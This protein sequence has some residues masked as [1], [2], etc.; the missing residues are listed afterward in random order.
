MDVV[1]VGEGPAIEEVEA[2]LGDVN[3]SP[4]RTTPE[5]IEEAGFAIVVDDVGS[6]TFQK[7]NEASQAGE[8][9]WI[10][11]EDGGVGGLRRSEVE[12]GVSGYSPAETGCYECLATRVEAG[13][14]DEDV[15]AP[16]DTTSSL[17]FGGAIAGR[18]T[19]HLLTG[20]VST[21]LGGVTEIPLDVER[22]G[23]LPTPGC[24]CQDPPDI[25]K[26]DYQPPRSVEDMF[27]RVT[28]TLDERV[29]PLKHVE[30]KSSY[31]AMYYEGRL[32]DNR[33]FSDARSA[34]RVHGAADDWK[35][36]MLNTIE[37][38]LKQYALGTYR[39]ETLIQGSPN[40][41]EFTIGPDMVVTGED[42]DVDD[43]EEMTWCLAR[44]LDN[45]KPGHVPAERIYTPSPESRLGPP[46]RPGVG[47]GSSTAE[48][49][50]EAL[51]EGI[52]R[53][54]TTISWYSTH[55]PQALSVTDSA[56]RTL[57]RR[58]NAEGLTV[59][60]VVTTQDI[61]VPVVSVAVH[62][63]GGWPACAVG[64]S[65]SLDPATAAQEALQD[66]IGNW[67]ALDDL[68]E[69]IAAEEIP[70]LARM[71]D[72]PDVIQEFVDPDATVSA[73]DIGPGA[74]PEGMNEY[75]AV[76]EKVQEAGLESYGVRLTQPDLEEIEVEVGAV[77]VPGAQP[78]FADE[79]IFGERARTVPEEQG[80]E[81]RLDRDLHPYPA[82]L[83][84]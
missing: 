30:E 36:A 72:N 81:P 1:L 34:E 44:R 82:H 22:R 21:L 9:A 66:A 83:I 19:V 45:G 8:T 70:E 38:G 43:D 61:D 68:G 14:D 62:R 10:A 13:A 49:M 18:E 17:R 6:E 16:E 51:Y 37:A 57:E 78:R 59:S 47:L 29:G 35:E 4:R 46:I 64:S 54:A 41:L 74:I 67:M 73:E 24:E 84:R 15:D 50:L 3:V 56:F 33:A 26:L 31:P 27:E 25:F 39:T 11:I 40:D 52:E 79:P 69:E 76:A 23:F 55:E 53:D 63:E 58:A 80:F 20:G 75:L 5:E 77:V 65:A 42:V 12:V 2:A 60:P 32:S 28:R 48:A 71:A 7:A